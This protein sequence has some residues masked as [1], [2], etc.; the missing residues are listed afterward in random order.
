[1]AIYSNVL[2]ELVSC[3]VDVVVVELLTYKNLI[4]AKSLDV[5]VL[6]HTQR[7]DSLKFHCEAF[8]QDF[9]TIQ[10]GKLGI[11]MFAT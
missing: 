6:N 1:M 2:R 5:N 8:S 3:L 10:L 11:I 4:F 9:Y 7:L